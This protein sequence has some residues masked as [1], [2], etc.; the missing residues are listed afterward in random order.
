MKIAVVGGYGVGLTMRVAHAPAA[1]ETVTGGVL[2][3][4]P[5][6]K[7]SNQAIAAARLGAEV[8]FFTAVGRD[9]AAQDARALW[10]AENVD[11]SRVAEKDAATMT[12]FIL[13]E[14]DGE[15]RIAI[16]PGALAELLAE[17]AEAFR[18]SIAAADLLVV[19]LEIPVEL[20]A[21]ALRIAREVGTSTLLNPAPAVPLPAEVWECVDI[22]TPNATEAGVLLGDKTPDGDRAT[23]ARALQERFGGLVVLTLGSEG[24]L[25]DDGTASTVV[26]AFVIDR[27]E[28]T[29][30][31]GDSFTAAL[32]VALV[33]GLDP[34]AAARF[35]A[36]SGALAATVRDVIP[37]LPSRE[38]LD[39]FLHH[40]HQKD[41]VIR[42]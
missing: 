40:S 22:I 21:R 2:S 13:V 24:A 31:A 7:G 33:E 4:G 12:G 5:G 3:A 15:N 37:S 14:P 26:P 1:G 30:G 36:G 19:S 16:A 8:S 41:G 34:V 11:A 10:I 6:G 17:D 23:L 42:V 25:V 28:D 32:S 18:D 9:S 20:A 27:V 29:T 38:V 35:A 39:E